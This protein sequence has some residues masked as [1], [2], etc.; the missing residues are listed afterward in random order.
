[1]QSKFISRLFETFDGLTIPL[2][3]PGRLTISAFDLRIH[4]EEP[5]ETHG[6]SGRFLQM[7][8]ELIERVESCLESL[9]VFRHQNVRLALV[10]FDV[11]TKYERNLSHTP[12]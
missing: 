7:G 12:E 10:R 5:A 11:D 2:H 3:H 8:P 9:P 4:S 1:M 6:R